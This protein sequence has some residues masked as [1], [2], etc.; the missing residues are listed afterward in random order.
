M[1]YSEQELLVQK[2]ILGQCSQQESKQLESLLLESPQLRQYYL[3][4]CQID[5]KLFDLAQLPISHSPPK[6]SPSYWQQWK[7]SAACI[8]IGLCLGGFFNQWLQAFDPPQKSKTLAIP[9]SIPNNSFEEAPVITGQSH[10]NQINTWYG[11][12]IE[13]IQQHSMTLPYQGKNMLLHDPAL[14]FKTGKINNY[15]L[16]ILPI[17]SNR[18]HTAGSTTLRIKAHFHATIK[19]QAEHYSLNAYTFKQNIDEIQSIYDVKNQREI[20][21]NALTGIHKALFTKSTDA[22]WQ[23]ITVTLDVPLETQYLVLSLG[24]NTPGPVEE[25]THHLVDHITAEWLVEE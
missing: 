4:S 7:V 9:Y 17:D 2:F 12:G 24:A 20:A 19:N 5:L 15:A 6:T 13:V 14:P 1:T 3:N 16:I 8:F 25:R 18:K 21:A 10:G 11:N 22:G 23:S